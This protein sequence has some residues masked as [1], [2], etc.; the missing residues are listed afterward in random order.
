MPGKLVLADGTTFSGTCFG[1]QRDLG[2][3]VVGEIVFNTSMFGYQEIL[4][5]PSYAGQVMCFTCPHIG[6]VGCNSEDVESSRVYTEGIIIRDLPR[7]VS[8]FRAQQSLPEYLYNNGIMGLAGIDTRALVT[9]LR[10]YGAQ[11]GVIA[12]GEKLNVDDMVSVARQQGSMEGKDYVKAV[13]CK[14]AYQW[15]ELPW[16]LAHSNKRPGNPQLAFEQL[17]SRPH[18]V[19]LDCG[20]KY[21]ILRL[22]VEVGFRVTVVPAT[23]TAEEILA[24]KPDG[25]FLSNGPGDPATLGY[26]VRA[27]RGVFGKVPIFGICLGHQILGQVVG[28]RTYKLKFGHRGGNHPVKYMPTGKVEITVQNHGFAVDPASLPSDVR[29][30]HV[31]LNDNTVEGLEIPHARAFCVQYHPEASPGPHDAN[32]LFRKFF[33]EVVGYRDGSQRMSM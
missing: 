2:D 3:P 15:N 31:N 6:N 18:V 4:T 5:D 20:I 30:S 1:A 21:N 22:L 26:I 23:A 27:V 10:T 32:Y 7:V 9:H 13:S 17:W 16:S 24:Q 29:I 33:E 12:C 11:M 19:A 14:T 28:G 25:V 8:N